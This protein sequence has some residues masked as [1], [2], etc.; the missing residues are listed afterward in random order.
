MRHHS[1]TQHQGLRD[2]E[3]APGPGPSYAQPRFWA[4]GWVQLGL[5]GWRLEG[6][7]Q[8]SCSRSAQDLALFPAAGAE[9]TLERWRGKGCECSGELR[10]GTVA[11]DLLIKINVLADKDDS[12]PIAAL[13][14]DPAR[15]RAAHSCFLSS[16]RPP[17]FSPRSGAESEVLRSSSERSSAAWACW[18]AGGVLQSLLLP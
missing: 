8:R 6:W 15:Q 2:G 11:V 13:S 17:L 9:L 7:S 18:L 14:Q 10:G 16:R 12:V 3:D 4:L 1:Q 5:P